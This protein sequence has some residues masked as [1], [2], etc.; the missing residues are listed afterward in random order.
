MKKRVFSFSIGCLLA[1]SVFSAQADDT[2]HGLAVFGKLQSAPAS[3]HVLMSKY[4]INLRHS[5]GTLPSQDQSGSPSDDKIYIQLGGDSCDANEGYKNIG[6]RFIGTADSAMGNSLANTATGSSAAQGVGISLTDVVGNIIIPNST[7]A[8]FPAA[9]SSKGNPT[10]KEAFFPLFL[11]LVQLKG[12]EATLG[13]V[14]TN[15]TVQIE[16]L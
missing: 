15:M 13:D 10:N 3:C 9:S 5:E 11:T 12:Q 1:T 16:R 4:V 2:P 7:V 6:L 8:L 14:Q